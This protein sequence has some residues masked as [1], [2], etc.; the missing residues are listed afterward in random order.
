MASRFGI[1]QPV[2][3]TEDARFLT[4]RGRY[5]DDLKLPEMCAGAVVYSPHAHARILRVDTSA[6]EAAEGVICV[7]TGADAQADRLG[8]IPPLFMLDDIGGPPG[9]RTKRPVLVADEVRCVG[10][11]VAFV[12]AE[13][14]NQARDAADLI[15]VEYEPLEAAAS[16]ASAAE[17]GAASVWPECKHNRC[18]SLHFGSADAVEA[19]MS[20][21]AHRVSVKLV[22]NRIS[23]NPIEPRCAVGI[24]DEADDAY[25]LHTSSQNPHGARHML[26]QNVLNIAETR[27]RVISP[28]V[29]GGFGMKA[30]PYPE[31][32]LVLW[33][34][35]KCG[36]PVKWVA[37]RSESLMGDNH[38]RDQLAEGELAL[39]ET[40]RVLALRVSALHNIGAY[41]SSACCAPVAFSM[42]LMPGVYDIPLID[43]STTAVFTHTSPTGPYRGAGRPEAVYMLERLM[44]EAAA[45]LGMDQ[46]EIRRRNLIQPEAI[47][48]ST[49]TYLTYDSG[50]FPRML[51]ECLAL[52]DW[53][54]YEARRRATEAKGLLRGR[55]ITCFLEYAGVFDDRME[56]RF[57]QQANATIVAGTHSHGQGHA[58]VYAQMVSDWLGVPFETI[59]FVQGDTDQVPFGRGTYAAR[60]S[61]VGGNALRRAADSAIAK[62]K[63][64][65]ASLLEVDA[66]TLDFEDGVFRGRGTNKAIPF[67]DVVKQ[68]FRGGHLP[69]GVDTG[70]DASGSYSADTP[71][72]PNGAHVC[73]VEVDPETGTVR[74]DRYATVD[75]VGRALNPMICHGQIVGGLAQG[76]GQALMEDVVYDPDS[77]QLLSGSFSDYGMPRAFDMPDVAAKLMEIPCAT[78]PIG[79]KGVGESGTIGGPPTI[80]NA[81]IDALRPLGVGHIDLPATPQKVW[82]AIEGARA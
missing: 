50:D 72:F 33:A 11:R 73:E 46:V 45:K 51:D 15:D 8:G 43:V 49:P 28:D 57:D 61:M 53:D 63:V 80:I 52:S 3:R 48:Y 1:G 71:N 38:G 24:Y 75:D 19:A 12:V 70:L 36:R 7:L 55:A 27:L 20:G 23:A 58:T 13:T 34:A 76:V 47:P 25:T 4:G 22:N 5:V 60:S 54:G 81:V 17:P 42:R 30:D 65:A 78:N 40:G 77:G 32:A 66:D 39:D 68:M 18:F 6:A 21:A 26:A 41:V 35:R 2:R 44:D 10:D 16:L 79:V 31:E 64:M 37:S 82:Q 29:G 9:Y 74:I 69:P 56:I 14:A 67:G 59:R 62:A